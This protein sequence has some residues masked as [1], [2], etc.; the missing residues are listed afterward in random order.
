MGSRYKVG[1]EGKRVKE[2]EEWRKDKD[3]QKSEYEGWGTCLKPHLL[4]TEQDQVHSSFI[5]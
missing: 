2:E 5:L 4:H 3:G 1:M